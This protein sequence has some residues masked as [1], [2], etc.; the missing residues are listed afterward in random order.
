MSDFSSVVDPIQCDAL[1]QKVMHE[2][3]RLDILV[4][5][6]GTVRRGVLTECTSDDWNSLLGVHLGGHLNMIRPSVQAMVAG[7]GGRIVNV[8]SGSGLLHTPPTS[9]AYA[10]AK[11]AIA[12]LTWHLGP[13]LPAG[14]SVNAVSPIANT[15]TSSPAAKRL[16][17]Q[18]GAELADPAALAPLFSALCSEEGG[19]IS[20]CRVFCNGR[21]I[22][23]IVPSHFLE[24]FPRVYRAI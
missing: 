8:T 14:I 4:N 13:Q 19:R 5:T 17:S 15:R 6:A 24:I 11:R 16:A 1:V 3:G 9:V 18:A 2:Y 12:A 7:R 20:G 21:E 22:S 10:T 23:K